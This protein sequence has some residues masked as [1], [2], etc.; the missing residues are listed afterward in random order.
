MRLC[1]TTPNKTN[2]IESYVECKLSLSDD[3]CF[4]YFQHA[5]SNET[6]AINEL[7]LVAFDT[8]PGARSE[9]EALYNNKIKQLLS[10][11][12]D[13]KRDTAVVPEIFSL[14]TDILTAFENVKV[15]SETRAIVDFGNSNINAFVDT[16]TTL[17][18]LTPEGV[19]SDP[20]ILEPIQTDLSSSTNIEVE[21]LYNQKGDYVYETD[22]FLDALSTSY[23]DSLT[24]DEAQR[25]KLVTYYTFNSI[26]LQRNWRTLINYRIYAN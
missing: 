14:T 26:P 22:K 17:S 13:N 11:I 21:A 24:T 5:G 15:G 7:G 12:Y 9:L 4:A 10:L 16:L 6:P 19:I 2:R 20:T 8:D 3:D 1:I 18:G 23:F 25:I